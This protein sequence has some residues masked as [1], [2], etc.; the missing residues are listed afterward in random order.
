[1]YQARIDG[2][3]ICDGSRFRNEDRNALLATGAKIGGAVYLARKFF[4]FGQV[5]LEFAE[6]GGS[7][8]CEGALFLQY[9]SIQ[10]RTAQPP[11]L[12]LESSDIKGSVHLK[13]WFF[14]LG[15]VHLHGTIDCRSSRLRRR[16]LHKSGR[17]R[18]P[19]E[20]RMRVTVR[21]EVVKQRTFHGEVVNIAPVAR[22]SGGPMALLLSMFT[23]VWPPETVLVKIRLDSESVLGLADR[24]DPGFNAFV[25]IGAG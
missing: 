19:R 13:K 18:D 15:R 11:A 14:A 5:N 17:M 8:N 4:A 12:N 21:I 3:L 2:N 22:G 9:P 16:P 20:S 6:I 25:E 10:N 1:L 7:L 24:I 23:F